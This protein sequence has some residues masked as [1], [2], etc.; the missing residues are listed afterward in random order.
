RNHVGDGV[1]NGRIAAAGEALL[2][3]RQRPVLGRGSL[4]EALEHLSRFAGPPA[5][6]QRI[7]VL[8]DDARLR[9]RRL[10][11]RQLVHVY[12]ELQN[13]VVALGQRKAAF[14]NGT[15]SKLAFDGGHAVVRQFPNRRNSRWLARNLGA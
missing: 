12:L 14:P 7:P 3:D 9:K 10:E 8:S 1:E 4:V 5:C 2:E 15:S 11:Q 6:L 13:V